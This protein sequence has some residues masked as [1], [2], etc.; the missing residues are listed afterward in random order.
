MA[1][2]EMRSSLWYWQ[3][4]ESNIPV[5]SSTMPD[6][7]PWPKISIVT[8]S[9]NQGQFIEETIRSVLF[10]G[11]PNLEYIIIDGGSTD[12]TVEII[13]KYE[14][15]ITYWVSE[16]DNGQTQAI[17]K[18]F[19]R[20]SGEIVAYLN[21]DD[22][23]MPYTLRLVA[24]IF[25]KFRQVQ[26]LT[27]FK[28]HLNA[29]YIVS[30]DVNVTFL[31]DKKLFRKGL[32]IL[33]I[34]GWNQQP[35]T[36]WTSELFKKVGGQFNES[37]DGNMDINL[38]IRFSDYEQLFFLNALIGL[39]RKHPE[40]KSQKIDNSW[41]LFEEQQKYLKLYPVTLRKIIK[42][43]YQIPGVRYLLNRLVYK[44]TGSMIV[45]NHMKNDWEI[46]VKS[47]F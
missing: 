39:M 35:S 30:P 20:A 43:C 14:D 15:K 33:P 25:T 6:R 24:E 18:G 17:N 32:H 46:Q 16:N 40:Q 27:G 38:W 45:W 26:W 42:Q 21:S 22:I 1:G 12:N 34:L 31:Y 47:I 13:K 7:K 23:Y 28:S 37:I 3:M 8:P 44:P 11:Y 29:G 19:S 10:Q 9:Y 41:E 36:F 5:F 4:N 2:N